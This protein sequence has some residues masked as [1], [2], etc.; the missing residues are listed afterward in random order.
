M[1]IPTAFASI[2]DTRLLSGV[3]T[4]RDLAFSGPLR[5]VIDNAPAASDLELVLFENPNIASPDGLDD[6]ST[7]ACLWRRDGSRGPYFGALSPSDFIFLWNLDTDEIDGCRPILHCRVT[8]PTIVLTDA[9]QP[10]EISFDPTTETFLQSVFFPSRHAPA[11][12]RKPP[13]ELPPFLRGQS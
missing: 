2:P 4:I 11:P 3:S 1:T 9:L 6:Y 8:K 10:A 12:S 13:K 7:W 5:H